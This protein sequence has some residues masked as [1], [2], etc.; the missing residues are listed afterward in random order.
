LISAVLHFSHS[1][2]CTFEHNFQFGI[3]YDMKVSDKGQG[4]CQT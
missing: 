4:K 2:T 1:I 3:T